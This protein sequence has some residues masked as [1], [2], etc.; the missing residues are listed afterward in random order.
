MKI[1][2]DVFGI[3]ESALRVRSQRLE[4]LAS[5]IANADTPNFKARDIDFK[6]VMGQVQKSALQATNSRHFATEKDDSSADGIRYRVPFNAS[7]DGN[8]VELSVEQAQFGK[9]GTDYRTSLMFI[10]NRANSI[11]KALRGE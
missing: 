1:L 5:N 10:E 6:V 2:S 9:A 3:H 4:L 11:K 8:T 7:M